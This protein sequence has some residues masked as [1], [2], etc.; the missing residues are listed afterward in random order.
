MP[1]VFVPES[2]GW[3]NRHMDAARTYHCTKKRLPIVGSDHELVLINLHLSAY[4]DGTMRIQEMQALNELA[5][6]VGGS[7]ALLR[8]C[9]RRPTPRPVRF[10]SR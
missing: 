1:V 10:A 8:Y 2:S 6:A 4:D 5:Q 3:V 7:R 9:Q